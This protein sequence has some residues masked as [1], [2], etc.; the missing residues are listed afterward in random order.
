MTKLLFDAL[1]PK[2]ARIAAVL[3]REG[4]GR[5]VELLITCRDYLH[6]SDVLEMYGVSHICVGRYGV[7][8]YEKLVYGLERQMRLA[9]LARGVDGMLSFPSPDAARVL[10]GLGKPLVVLN[11]TPHAEHVNRLVIPLSNV[12]I[13]P[14]AVPAE[15]WRPYCPRRVVTFDGVFEYMWISRFRPDEDVVRRLG[16]KPGEYVVFRPEEAHA[17][18]YRWDA[19]GIRA[20]LLAELRRRGYVV[21]NV[22]RYPDQLV[23]GVVNL[24]KA[25]DH[26]QLAYFSAGVVS[27]GATM[28]TEAA[29]L[30]VPALSYF[31]GD[32]HLDR[33][34]A[35]RGAPLFRCRDAETCASAL[36][37]MLR[38]GRTQPPR[39]EDPTPLILE[40]ALAAVKK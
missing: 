14:A 15:A 25:V 18:Y 27:G 2:Q 9:E 39:L 20:V 34:L 30:G 11:D 33:Y 22:P 4:A 8:L 19:G 37:E 28:A 24:T 6:L 32:Y 38:L 40:E 12:L 16:L 3:Q 36:D 10:F 5:G 31:P 1:T 17:A 35:E 26:L 29:L 23:E 21:V 13:A 7:G